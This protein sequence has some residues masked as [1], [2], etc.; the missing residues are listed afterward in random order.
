VDGTIAAAPVLLI[1]CAALIGCD[2]GGNGGR[3][4]PLALERLAFVSGTV[5]DLGGR[6][7]CGDVGDLLVDR[8]EVSR[9]QWT[10]WLDSGGA[11]GFPGDE[12]SSWSEDDEAWPATWMALEEAGA[13]AEHLGMRLPTACEWLRVAGGAR[14]RSW[15]WGVGEAQAVANTL[16]LGLDRL[17]AGGTFERGRSPEGV[18]DLLGNAAEWT[19]GRATPALA[20]RGHLNG[21]MGG[22]FLTRR[23]PLFDPTREVGLAFSEQ[24][25][26]PR[27]RAQDLGFRCVAD[28]ESFLL[29]RSTR[30]ENDPGTLKRLEAL[31]RSW[32]GAAVPLL[33]SLASRAGAAP[34]LGAL[35]AGARR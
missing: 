11:P 14:G 24:G 17:L 30:W 9:G 7:S 13:Y 34:G 25:F 32:G 10:R 5:L 21:A 26:D 22:S 20:E 18:Y 35:L 4:E 33:E 1:S 28:A 12:R 27:H 16:D 23:R 6:T 8:F 2:R 19:R 3:A 15:P 31:G 29:D